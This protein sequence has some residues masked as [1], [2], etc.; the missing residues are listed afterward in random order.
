MQ[1]NDTL[2]TVGWIYTSLQYFLQCYY[3]PFK[4]IT[5]RVLHFISVA[6]TKN[7]CIFCECE[8]SSTLVSSTCYINCVWS[9]DFKILFCNQSNEYIIVVVFQNHY[10]NLRKYMID[11]SSKISSDIVALSDLKPSDIHVSA[12]Y[13]YLGQCFNSSHDK[14]PRTVQTNLRKQKTCKTPQ[15]SPHRTVGIVN[16]TA[17]E[18]MGCITSN[19]R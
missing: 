17:N 7:I 9:L 11:L 16:V 2:S 3:R 5:I 12:K 15:G 10:E 14:L 1:I 13:H 19:G 8:L 18:F 6:T 4:L